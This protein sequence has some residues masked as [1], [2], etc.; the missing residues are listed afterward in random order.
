MEVTRSAG[1]LAGSA[2]LNVLFQGLE[3][4]E[5]MVEVVRDEGA[6]PPVRPGLLELLARPVE[7][8]AQASPEPVVEPLAE[9]KKKALS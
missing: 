9:A 7:G 4:L 3:A 6:S 8:D 5:Q 2:E 1:S